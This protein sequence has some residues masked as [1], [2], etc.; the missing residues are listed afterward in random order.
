MNTKNWL[1]FDHLLI[2]FVAYREKEKE[3]ERERKVKLAS[4]D[5][6]ILFVCFKLK[7]QLNIH[8]LVKKCSQPFCY[9]KP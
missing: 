7:K 2:S 5:H 4:F 1:L 6:S 8:V 9:Q 3:R